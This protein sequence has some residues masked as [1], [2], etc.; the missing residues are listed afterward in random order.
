MGARIK[1]V[2]P[3]PKKRSCME[4][5]EY[6]QPRIRAVDA[7][8]EIDFSWKDQAITVTDMRI[9]SALRTAVLY[10]QQEVE[11]CVDREEGDFNRRV[12]DFMKQAL[13]GR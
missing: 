4:F 10:T 1:G 8:I 7:D 11:N 9:P 12:Q 13:R 3:P 5:I 6:W 2:K